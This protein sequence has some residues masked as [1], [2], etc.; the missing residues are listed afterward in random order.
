MYRFIYTAFFLFV[1]LVQRAEAALGSSQLSFHA[2]ISVKSNARLLQTSVE[3]ATCTED[4][5]V[6][7]M[8]NMSYTT[9]EVQQMV[10]SNAVVKHLYRSHNSEDISNTHAQT[11]TNTDDSDHFEDRN[12]VFLNV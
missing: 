3:H 7:N 5:Y 9:P 12:I 2:L 4:S 8:F 11:C 10:L 1:C 6:V